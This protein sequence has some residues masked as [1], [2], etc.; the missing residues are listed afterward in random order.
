MRSRAFRWIFVALLASTAQA[1]N[2]AGG[3]IRGVWIPTPEH[4]RFFDDTTMMRRDLELWRS[5]GINT[6]FVAVWNQGRTMYPSNVVQKLTGVRI[7]PAM[8]N[9]D[10]LAEVIAI[11]HRLDVKVYAWFEYGFASDYRGGRG[12]EILRAHPE[13]AALDARGATVEK[14]GF[15]WMNAL[16]PDVQEFLLALIVEAAATHDLDGVQ[17]DDRLPA[18]PSEAGYNP[19]TVARYRAEHGGAAPPTNARDSAWV[20][21]RSAQLDDFM[22]RLH[23]HVKALKPSLQISMAPGVYPFSRT[24]YLQDWPGWLHRGWVDNV[25]PQLYRRDIVAYERELQ[26]ITR[27]QLRPEELSKVSP[28]I[29]LSL[30]SGYLA[31]AELVRQMVEANRRAGIAGEVFFF[32]DGVTALRPTF[33]K[34]YKP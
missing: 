7:H 13:W 32:A 17:G 10:P 29:L 1:Q 22:H 25:S 19:A 16:D 15:H 5:L 24:D 3:A 20:N 23:D 2:R 31:E 6:I 14:N 34:L 30:S 8:A 9:R 27:E 18:L 12:S 33:E 11:A 4:T 21:W 26:R 28:G